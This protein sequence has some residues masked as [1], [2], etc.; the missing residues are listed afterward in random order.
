[1]CHADHA[2]RRSSQDLEL[3]DIV[4]AHAGDLGH[5]TPRQAQALSAIASCRTAAL[6]G[7][8]ASCDSC[9][10]SQD[11]YNSCRDRHCPK[12]QGAAQQEW[13]SRHVADVLPVPYFH[14]VFTIADDLH[15]LFLVGQAAAY[16]RLFAAAARTLEEV[17]ANPSRL[18][19]RLGF[20]AVLHTWTQTLLY[21]PHVHV[22]VPGGGLSPDG[23]CWRESRNGFFLPVRVLATVFRGKLLSE[24]ERAVREQDIRFDEADA[25]RALKR[26][27]R[28]KWNVYAKPPFGGPE[29]VIRY[30]GRYTHRIAI[31]NP[32][33]LEFQDGQV[34]FAYRDREASDKRRTM[35][36]P[37]PEFLR[38]FLLHVL[39]RG[40]QRIRHYGFLANTVRRSALALCRAHLKD[41]ATTPPG[42]TPIIAEATPKDSS[43]DGA[44]GRK[45]PRCDK[46]RL[47]R[48]ADIPTARRW[49][50]TSQATAPP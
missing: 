24:L 30:L 7:H 40:F 18:G 29:A 17:A 4:R 47:V 23:T 46:G 31:S 21:H 13:V 11:V 45:C 20:I 3:A 34:T 38:R 32:R 10:F 2:V 8:I 5:L 19:V 35:T 9:D 48:H 37:A 49:R 6:G 1:M 42:F 16:G 22:L 43:H 50:W 39:P 36:L 41:R 14:I 15:P 12:C 27:A 25:R 33:L 28:K 44:P 26:A